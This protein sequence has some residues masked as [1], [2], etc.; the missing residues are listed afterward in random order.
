MMN[1]YIAHPAFTDSQRAFKVKFFHGL[2][3]HLGRLSH[4]ATVSLIDPFD[5]SPN[6]E[7]CI[8]EKL[9]HARNIRESCLSLLDQCSLLIALID[10]DDT[11]TAFEAGYAYH[12]SIPVIIVSNGSCDEANAMLLGAAHARFDN[13][14]DAFQLSLLAGLIEWHYLQMCGPRLVPSG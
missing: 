2:K 10:D 1:V 14:L 7:G 3:E 13:I 8:E 9:A 4:C 6:V 11:G 12:M 5:H